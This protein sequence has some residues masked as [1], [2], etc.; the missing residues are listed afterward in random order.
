MIVPERITPETTGA[1]LA[2]YEH[3]IFVQD[4]LWQVNSFDQWGVELGKMLSNRIFEKIMESEDTEDQ[5]SSTK[6]LIKRFKQL[7]N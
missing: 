1:L 3:K 6:D 5:D 4:T 7:N 2:L